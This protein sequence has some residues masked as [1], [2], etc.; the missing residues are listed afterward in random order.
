MRAIA[1]S[2]FA[3][4]REAGM[5]GAPERFAVSARHQEILAETLAEIDGFIRVFERVTSRSA[6]AKAAVAGAP[7]IARHES[8]EV[9]FFSAWD[10]HLQPGPPEGWQ[11]IEFNDNGSG[12]LF[13]ALVNR[14]FYEVGGLAAPDAVEPPPSFPEF[15]ERLAGMVEREAREFFGERPQGCFLILDDA[16]SLERGR[17]L[18]ELVLLRG[19]I[20]QHGFESA[21]AS[22]QELHG[23]GPRLL[24]AGRTVSFVVNRSTDFFWETE[25]FAPL[26]AAWQQ[27]V[28][29]AA[30]NPF[31]YATRSDKRLLELLSRPD[32]DEEL[33]IRPEE[34]AVLSAHVPE[35]WRVSEDNLDALV[36]RKD[37][38]V[39]K[40]AHGFAGRGL[41][42]SAQVGR[43]RLRR[44]LARGHEYVAQRRVSKCRLPMDDAEQPELWADLRV[45][46]YRGERFLLSGRASL[47]PDGID[48][49]P[50]GGWLATYRAR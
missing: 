14:A 21:I 26:R 16:E 31:T 19:L 33:G 44:L 3:A 32:H 40:P 4:L 12:F 30:P 10:F 43:S 6:W 7:E 22:P 42:P 15:A 25:A 24:A 8:S 27:G 41:L 1:E 45:W 2:F 17:F 28:V 50:P 23:D 47:R 29:Y 36:R 46:A 9:C 35:T 20:E 48:L 18:D 13:A 39:F 11:L 34:R 38:L 49:R 37:D 5:S